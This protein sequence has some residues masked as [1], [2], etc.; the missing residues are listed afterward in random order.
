[1]RAIPAI[2]I[3]DGQCVRLARGDY[4][5][6]TTYDADPA[7]VAASWQSK[8]ATL[9]HVVDLD[10]A[11]VGCPVNASAISRLLRS[12]SVPIEVGGGI[13]SFEIA[14]RLLSEGVHRIVLGTVAVKQPDLARRLV[15]SFTSDRI[16]VGIDA[17]RGQVATSGWMD[18]HS[19]NA[20]DVA[21][22]VKSLGVTEVI[23]TDIDKDG[24]MSGP[25]V[26]A[27]RDLAVES[28]LSVI[29]SGGVSSIDDLI[30]LKGLERHG[31]TGVIVGKALYEGMIELKDAIQVLAADS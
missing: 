26:E 8:G 17:K 27:T 24:M 21:T 19:V 25:N 14:S 7:A 5:Q 12:V 30:R 6:K 9:I 2:D 28:G 20:V 23:Y 11:R 13:R 18:T 10:G 31:V 4:G 15:D 16:V 22:M 29:A 1:M 3:I